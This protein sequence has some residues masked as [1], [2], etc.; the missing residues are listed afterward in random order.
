[1]RNP[2]NFPFS[3]KEPHAL[4]FQ[5]IVGGKILALFINPFM[6]LLTIMYFV[7]R[8][9]V[10]PAIEAMYPGPIFY[11]AAFSLVFGDFLYMYYYMIGCAKRG[12]YSLIKFAFFV[13][14][15]WLG[16]SIASWRALYEIFVKPHYWSKTKHGL[17][18]KN[19]SAESSK[20]ETIIEE[21]I[22]VEFKAK[23]P[24]L[25]KNRPRRALLPV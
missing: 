6:W 5:L 21:V 22:R 13:P 2:F 7:M 11:M 25:F 19:I 16:M 24:K 20:K 9:V 15:Y 18:L 4:T 23:R 14:I 17:H 12:Q 1:M 8:S 10:G 3:F